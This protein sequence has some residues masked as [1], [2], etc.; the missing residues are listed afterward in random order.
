M[1]FVEDQVDFFE[2]TSFK[3]YQRR[4]SHNP[5]L[6]FTRVITPQL[7]FRP[8]GETYEVLSETKLFIDGFVLSFVDD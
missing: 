4:K 7:L 8:S 5:G 3:S 6:A 1:F 2:H